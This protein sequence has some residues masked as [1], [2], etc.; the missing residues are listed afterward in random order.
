MD[1]KTLVM[2]LPGYHWNNNTTWHILEQDGTL[3]FKGK[4]EDCIKLDD[5]TLAREV[6]SYSTITGENGWITDK[7]VRLV[8][9]DLEWVDYD[10][11]EEP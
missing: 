5:E 6:Y 9:S 7:F 3:I 8:D 1:L 2:L 4:W 10:D 11:I